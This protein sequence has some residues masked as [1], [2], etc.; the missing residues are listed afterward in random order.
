MSN[1]CNSTR[2]EGAEERVATPGAEGMEGLTGEGSTGGRDC[3]VGASLTAVA[4]GA[5]VTLACIELDTSA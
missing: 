1:S 4:A 2:G 3:G 5:T